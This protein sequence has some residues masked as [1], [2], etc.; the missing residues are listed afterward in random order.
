MKIII[1][2]II[3]SL[4]L[5]G[6]FNS[7]TLKPEDTKLTRSNLTQADINDL[8]VR[9]AKNKNLEREILEEIRIAEENQDS[10]AF[11]FYL[12]EY[13]KVERLKIPDWMKKEPNY[14]EGGLN[15]KY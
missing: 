4:F 5:C 3:V 14:V 10:D 2:L 6:C 9:D 8:L 7:K 11:R 1:N 12:Q 15:V 13:M